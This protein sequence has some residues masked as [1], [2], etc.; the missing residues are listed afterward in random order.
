MPAKST[1]RRKNSRKTNPDDIPSDEEMADSLSSNKQAIVNALRD[2]RIAMRH[3]A[4]GQPLQLA[5]SAETGA[6][7]KN[8]SKWANQPRAQYWLEAVKLAKEATDEAI[9]SV[10]EGSQLMT[11]SDPSASHRDK[12]AAAALLAKLRGLDHTR[13]EIVKS[14]FDIQFEKMLASCQVKS[15][16]TDPEIIDIPPS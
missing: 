12:T 13:F 3:V 7:G 15:F 9:A 16:K 2:I 4:G 8:A 1:Y 6:T 10:I 11:L 14:D 5:Y